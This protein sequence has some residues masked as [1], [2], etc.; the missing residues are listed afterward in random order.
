MF[1]NFEQLI[2][3]ET[4][5]TKDELKKVCSFTTLKKL[6][7]KQLLL[8]EG[9]ICRHKIFVVKGLLRNYSTK[10]DGTEYNMRFTPENYW[11]IDAASYN[12][13]QPSKLNI[14]ALE[15]TEVL[16][17]QKED[18]ESLFAAIPAFKLYSEKL[19]AGSLDASQKRVLMNISFT[20]E[21]KYQEF[22]TSFPDIFQRVPLHMVASYR[23][24]SRETLSR[25]RHARI[26]QLTSREST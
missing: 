1:E 4:T 2:L 24:V 7:R 10:D 25:V 3:S 12:N 17:W 23:G 26:K 13:R 11:T 9:E 15:N 21:E 22:I 16:L 20:P 18:M 8:H 6:R 14:E 5:L 19:I